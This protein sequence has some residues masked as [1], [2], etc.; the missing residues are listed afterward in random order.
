MRGSL[1]PGSLITNREGEGAEQCH[2]CNVLKE[3]KENI[4]G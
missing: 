2:L 3:P 1:R 4:E